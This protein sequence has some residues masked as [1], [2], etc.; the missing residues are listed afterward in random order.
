[1]RLLPPMQVGTIIIRPCP[2]TGAGAANARLDIRA[3][4][5]CVPCSN[6]GG[7]IIIDQDPKRCAVQ[8]IKL[9]TFQRPEK[10]AETQ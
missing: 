4:K 8:I 2:A 6:I 9:A 1:M 5:S 10:G 7:A 3:T